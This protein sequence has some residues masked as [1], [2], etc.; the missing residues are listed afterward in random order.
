MLAI[1]RDLLKT[2]H[3]AAQ[4]YFS[5]FSRLQNIHMN[6]VYSPNIKISTFSILD[7][8][9]GASLPLFWDD[10]DANRR[11]IF[12]IV[13]AW[14]KRSPRNKRLRAQRRLWHF[15]SLMLSL[16]FCSRL[17]LARFFEVICFF[18][19]KWNPFKFPQPAR[20]STEKQNVIH[21]GT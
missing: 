7:C 18:P 14:K 10:D 19:L 4:V 13:T 9:I 12:V 2:F 6:F 15:V 8:Q 11:P 5:S 3:K 21:H 16:R 1:R 20:P 17:Y